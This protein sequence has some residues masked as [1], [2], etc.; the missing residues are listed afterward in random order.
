MAESVGYSA[1][2]RRNRPFRRLWYG[3]VVSQLGDW[4]DSIALYALLP[5][6]TG[7]ERSVGILLL[8]QYLPATV[9][10]WWAGVLIDRVPRKLV[11]IV[12]DLV[13]AA[14]VFS[15]L[16]IRSADLVWLVYVIVGLKFV[17]AAFFEP[18][19]TAVI[20]EVTSRDELIAANAIGGATWSAMLAIGAA[21]GGLVAGTLGTQA[22]FVIDGLTFVVS[23]LLIATVPIRESHLEVRTQTSGLHD[24]REGFGY[25]LSNRDVA[26]YALT[27]ALW[28]LG[29]GVL[30]VLTL[31]GRHVFPLGVNGAL[32]IGLLYAARGVGAGVGP[33]IAQR[34]GGESVLFLRRMIGPSF[35]LSTLGYL[36]MSGSPYLWLALVAAVIAHM[37]GSIEWVYS[38]ALLQIKVPLRLQGRVFAVEMG[39]M[40]L[41]TALSSYA[42][43]VLADAGWEPRVLSLAMALVFVPPGL[44]LA[45]LL[46]RAPRSGNPDAVDD[47][48]LVCETDTNPV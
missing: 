48:R 20:P 36:I 43:S 1:L 22:A 2:I 21:L 15:L 16:F 34:F 7:S 31:F 8:A 13:R 11:L 33:I 25:M 39:I 42:V 24:L 10:S 37:G 19:R 9:V 28:S 14:L 46:W 30:V 3:Q 27:K 32:S 47:T 12:T 44:A 35:L 6:L 40:T 45:L 23:A 26:I 17:M 29:G 18:A 4:F 38:T 41:T 5:Q